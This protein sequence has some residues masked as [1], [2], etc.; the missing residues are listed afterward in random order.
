MRMNK[1][2]KFWKEYDALTMVVLELS[3]LSLV[4]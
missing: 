2:K 3:I 4:P 1:F